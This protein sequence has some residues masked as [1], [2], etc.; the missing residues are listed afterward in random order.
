MDLYERYAPIRANQF[1]IAVLKE[2]LQDTDYKALKFAE[3]IITEADYEPI[4]TQRQAY[5]DEINRL[6]AEDERLEAEIN[7]Q[8]E[9]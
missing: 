5:R 1:Q 6:E 7:N 2:Q 3:G 9:A 8:I 4:K